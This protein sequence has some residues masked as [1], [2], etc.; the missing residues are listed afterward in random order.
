[1]ADVLLRVWK[2]AASGDPAWQKTCIPVFWYIPLFIQHIVFDHLLW[3]PMIV[4]ALTYWSYLKLVKNHMVVWR[5]F[6]PVRMI[7][8]Y[9]ILWHDLD[10]DMEFTRVGKPWPVAQT[11]PSAC[12]CKHTALSSHLHI[13]HGCF[14]ESWI[15]MTHKAWNICYLALYK[16]SLPIPPQSWTLIWMFPEQLEK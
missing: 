3:T 10:V 6:Q 8:R 7:H 14:C 4:L 16:K 1:M 2:F 15:C 11:S 5:S 12:F 9:L 13:V